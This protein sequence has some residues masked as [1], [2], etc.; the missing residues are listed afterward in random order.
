L[1][2]S[3]LF[4]LI[5]FFQK[6]MDGKG[7]QI[8]MVMGRE[9]MK[10][11]SADDSSDDEGYEQNQ[12]GFME[13]EFFESNK[14]KKVV[15]T[16][17]AAAGGGRRVSSGGGGGMR[18]CQVEKCTANLTDAKQYHRR[19]KVCGH[20]AKAQVVLVAGIRQRFCQQC[21]R[22]EMSALFFFSHCFS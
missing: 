14:K 3:F 19:H 8:R 10:K 22:L 15:V 1:N 12:M 21:S 16:A 7:K 2:P 5:F 6:E 18:C 17:A 9:V 4:S 20:H 13:D 11:D